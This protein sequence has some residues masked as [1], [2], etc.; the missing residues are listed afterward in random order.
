MEKK[1]NAN[2][3]KL[4]AIIAMTVDHAADLLFPGYS[5]HPIA[6]GLHIIGR[7]TAPIMWFFVCE[8][9]FYTRNLPKYLMRMGLFAVISHF[10]YCFA[11]GIEVVPF[12]GGFFNQT[13]VMWPLFW[14]VVAL[15]LLNSAAMF[16]EWQKWLL[17]TLI[18]LITFPADWSCIAVMAIVSMYSHRGNLKNQMNW[19][20]FWVIVYAVVSFIFVNK[21]YAVVQLGV[22]LVYPL[23]LRYNGQKGPS[24]WMKWFFYLYYP[25]H[26]LIA[27]LIRLAVYGD[28][29]LLF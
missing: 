3:L 9:F 18:N 24:N 22:V 15:W 7:L 21:T 5:S 26:L 2:H 1:L 19:M 16:K 6:L 17:I 8:G 29:P 14:A 23:L 10:A 20:M 28:V 27:G 25:G 12:F 11:F 4:I 13:S